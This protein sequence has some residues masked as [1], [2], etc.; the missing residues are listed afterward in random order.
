MYWSAYKQYGHNHI[1]LSASC[2]AR[3]FH[4]T[5]IVSKTQSQWYSRGGTGQLTTRLECVNVCV[6]IL[7]CALVPVI[8]I[9][10]ITW[11][12]QPPVDCFYMNIDWTFYT[13]C[14]RCLSIV[15]DWMAS[16][17]CCYWLCRNI[18]SIT[19][20]VYRWIPRTKGQWR[21]R[22]FHLMTSSWIGW[23]SHFVV[24]DR[25]DLTV[26][27]FCL[28]FGYRLG[29]MVFMAICC[30]LDMII[31]WM[32]YTICCCLYMVIGSISLSHPH[33]W[34][35]EMAYVEMIMINQP[36]CKSTNARL[37]QRHS[38]IH[39]TVFVKQF[40]AWDLVTLEKMTPVGT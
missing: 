22:C 23:P 24:I 9:F 19:F 40:S 17:A 5:E 20:T 34:V 35:M 37:N 33:I 2:P 29:L 7:N 13:T 16:T 6:L 38:V 10:V 3:S 31:D 39:N 30:C 25:V 14:Y 28:S 21:G 8:Y 12:L 4:A 18:D 1:D 36:Y 32:A 15:I 26:C 27:C 11:S